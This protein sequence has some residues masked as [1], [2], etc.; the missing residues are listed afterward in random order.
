MLTPPLLALLICSLLSL[1]AASQTCTIPSHLPETTGK[2]NIG[3]S[4][5]IHAPKNAVWNTVLNFSSYPDWNPFVRSQIVADEFAIPLDNQTAFVGAKIIIT[6]QI[7]PLPQ[8]VDASTPPDILTQHITIEEITVIDAEN[9]RVAWILVS[10]QQILSTIR[11]SAVS[12]VIDK[13]GVEKSYYESRETFD[14]PLASIVKDLL[15]T[16]IA[17]SFQAQADALKVWMEA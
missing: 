12:T 10:P 6:S 2:V 5:L 14:G 17:E 3:G 1:F 15:G 16:D 11:W 9:Y 7:P 4:S 13:D 8:A